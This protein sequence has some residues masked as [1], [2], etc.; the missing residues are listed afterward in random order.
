MWRPGI[1]WNVDVEVEVR[2]VQSR[3]LRRHL[4]LPNPHHLSLSTASSH[5]LT[6]MRCII[7]VLVAFIAM[8]AAAPV[9]AYQVSAL[10]GFIRSVRISHSP[11]T[12]L[13][14]MIPTSAMIPSAQ[15][16]AVEALCRTKHVSP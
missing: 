9:P 4:L 11:S 15:S 2:D 13:R 3:S 5:T 14:R 8:A 7:L 12:R 10:A 16:N 1:I 6:D